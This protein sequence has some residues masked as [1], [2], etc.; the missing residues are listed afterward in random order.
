[1]NYDKTIDKKWQKHWADSR[2][3]NVDVKNT[4]NKYYS[5]V[6]FPYPSNELH[7]GHA[8]NYVI[9]DAVSRY[10]LM[11]GFNVLSPMGWDS[12]GLPAENQAIKR[13]IQPKDW[14]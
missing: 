10:K 8:R 7:A 13:K 2:L 1:M 9:G 11:Q 14:T 4:K 12:F 3:F 6:M 5:L